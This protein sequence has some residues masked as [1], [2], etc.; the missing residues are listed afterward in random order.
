[1]NAGGES[2]CFYVLDKADFTA[3]DNNLWY[4]SA[5]GTAVYANVNST[6][7]HF[8]DFAAWKTAMT[9]F[10]ANSLWED[11]LMTD[12]ATGDFTLQATSPCINAG[13]DVGLTTD[14]LGNPIVG[15]PDI[16]AYEDQG[17]AITA[18]TIFFGCD[19]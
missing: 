2:A 15:L 11:P 18:V 17:G 6:N 10:E 8:D 12:P 14:Y 3:C 4:Q 7:Y 5:G 1:M 16:G 19:F 13:V 9:P